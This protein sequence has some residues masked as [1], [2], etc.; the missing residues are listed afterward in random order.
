VESGRALLEVGADANELLVSSQVTPL[1][2][3]AAGRHES[4]VALLLEHGA[5]PN[6]VDANS[7]T[8]LH[9]AAWIRASAGIV[10]LLLDHGA[11]PNVRLSETG[12]E[13][14]QVDV[15]DRENTYT[16]TGISMNGATPFLM[17]S[18]V[19]SLR[20]MRAL[21]DAGADP[22]ITTEYGTNALLLAAGGGTDFARPR[23]LQEREDSL[24]AVKMLVELG[25]DV[26]ATG[27][28]D[29]TAVHMA[30]FQGLNDVVRYLVEEG[31][32]VNKMDRY[33]QTPLSISYAI[34]TV[35][36]ER[37]YEQSPKIYRP[38]TAELLLASG[39]TPLEQSGVNILTF[40]AGE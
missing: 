18:E 16:D 40:K 10:E 17:A 11:D 23:S 36:A 38:D 2:I 29:W 21:L 6:V 14:R 33:G 37:A 39:A 25:L 1:L 12:P 26:N 31:A 15:D 24:E 5:D 20:A 32:D 3:A 27:E 8:P 4:F 7:H 35:E 13:E 30:S 34:I 28:F 19:S 9:H 22:T